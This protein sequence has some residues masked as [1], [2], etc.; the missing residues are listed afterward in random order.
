MVLNP[1]FQ[2]YITMAATKLPGTHAEEACW[3]RS[4]FRRPQNVTKP[5]KFAFTVQEGWLTKCFNSRNPKQ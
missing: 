2:N 4:S 1:E 5:E 3:P